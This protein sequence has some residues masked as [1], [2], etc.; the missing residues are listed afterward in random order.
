MTAIVTTMTAIVTV[1]TTT[2]IDRRYGYLMSV[3]EKI[4][5]CNDVKLLDLHSLNLL[6]DEVREKIISVTQKRGGHIA[7]SLGAVDLIVALAFCFDFSR[8]KVVFDVGH[9]AYAYKILTDR[10]ECFSSL[11]TFDG[12]SGFPLVFE[13][14]YD[15]F[16]SGHAGDSVAAALGFCFSRD[17]KGDD[18]YV[19]AVVGDGSILNGENLES[20]FYKVTKPSK[21]LIILNDNGM[22]IS[23]NESGIFDDVKK[24]SVISQIVNFDKLGLNYVGPVDG[25]DITALIGAMNDFKVSRIPTLLHV[26]TVKGKGYAPAEGEAEYY[27]GVGYDFLTPKNDFSDAVAP[28]LSSMI[29]KDDSIVVIVAGMSFGTGV[30]AVRHKYP[31]NFID[32]GICEDLA[33][34]FA[35]A[36]ALNGLKPVVLIYSTFLQRAYDQ[37]VTNVCLQKLPVIFMIDR[38]GVVGADGQTHQG[39]YDIS[40]LSHIPEISV[41]APKNPRELSEML[42]IA[43]K[44][45]T[46]VAIRYPNGSIGEFESKSPFDEKES[47]EVLK[48]GRG[49]CILACGAVAIDISLKAASFTDASVINARTIKPLDKTTLL[50]YIDRD[51]VTVEDN[52]KAGGFGSLVATFL[53]ENGYKKKLEIFALKDEFIPQGTKSEQLEGS[54]I[55]VEA[56]KKTLYR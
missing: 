31:K 34:T 29:E 50:K 36:C 30:D 32:V 15:S 43:L 49:K 21:L 40:Y 8:D 54:G 5:N 14:P 7:S 24:P 55:F 44:K 13:S 33:V 25:H 41:F 12:I 20:L 47:W 42:T 56:I 1:T 11:R 3:L 23:K 27:H 46:P 17:K 22:S 28:V 48:Q 26:K 51:I 38:A 37:I 19:V 18:E 52:V 6:S 16:S 2:N 53:V 35:S 10:K 4:K 39:A 9:Q 45:G